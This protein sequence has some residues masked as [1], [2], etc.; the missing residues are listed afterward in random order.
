MNRN[1]EYDL[2]KGYVMLEN[3]KWTQGSISR[4]AISTHL[5]TTQPFIFHE[6][7]NQSNCNILFDIG[8][9]IGLYT[10]TAKSIP[11]IKKIYSFEP[12]EHAFQHL[13]ANIKL[14]EMEVIAEPINQAISDQIKNVRFGI[15]GPA[16]GINGVIETSFHDHEKYNTTIEV[17]AVPV[18]EIAGFSNQRIAVKIDVEGH[19]MEALRGCVRTLSDNVCIVQVEI[20][21]NYAIVKKLLSDVG[22]GQIFSIANDYYFTNAEDFRNES[23]NLEIVQTALT[24]LAKSR[25]GVS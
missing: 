1:L 14:N 4:N 24:T 21:K 8:A 5:E 12:E 6:Y 2:K 22:Y 11:S 25:R 23:R 9:N 20:Y 13:L 19:E 17:L 3:F 10:I 15:Q 16:S 18:D 7:M